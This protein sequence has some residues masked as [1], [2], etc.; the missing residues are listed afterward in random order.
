MWEALRTHPAYGTL[1]AKQ[2]PQA[3]ILR[4]EPLNMERFFVFV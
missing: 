3:S 1:I 4:Q 2:I